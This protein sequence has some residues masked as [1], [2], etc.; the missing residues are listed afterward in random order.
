ML[1]SPAKN[2]ETIKYPVLVSP[3][4]DG[5]RALLING[6]LLTRKFKLVPNRHIRAL[7]EGAGLP[8]GLD[9]ELLVGNTFQSSSSGIMSHDGEPDFQYQVFDL[10]ETDL[11]EPFSVRYAK[12]KALVEEASLSWLK[13]VPHELVLSPEELR[14][15][16]EKY[17]A[18]AYEGLMIRSLEGPY[19]TGRSTVK[20][21]YLLKVKRFS[22]SE[23]VVLSSEERL[24]NANE[25]EQDAFGRTKRST[26]KENL[27][28]AGTLGALLV[29]DLVTKVE[30]SVGTGFTDAQRAELWADRG[31]LV[32]KI[33]KYRYQPTGVKEET[34]IPRFPIFLGWRDPKDM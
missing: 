30:F 18:Q 23:A 22:D 5:I 10:V 7:V 29:R 3:K 12:L 1:A 33:L 34:Q 31:A 16:E 2:L 26:V 9:G 21:G 24:H 19:K 6:S 32:G 4:L 15:K 20:E 13:L 25:A 14:A 17:L 27:V 8:S 28:P 11:A